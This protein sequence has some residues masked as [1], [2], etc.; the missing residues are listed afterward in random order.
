ML[1]RSIPGND[2][3]SLFPFFLPDVKVS[4]YFMGSTASDIR[5]KF[6]N[7]PPEHLLGWQFPACCNNCQ[8]FKYIGLSLL[9]IKGNFAGKLFAI[10]SRLPFITLEGG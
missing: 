8:L 6:S 1:S 10:N 4:C 2:N 7:G 3:V 5:F 9:D